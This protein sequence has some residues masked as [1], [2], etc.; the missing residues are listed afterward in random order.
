MRPGM[1]W[2][3]TTNG[4]SL[5]GSGSSMWLVWVFLR[6]AVESPLPWTFLSA[7][8]MVPSSGLNWY[9]GAFGE[10]QVMELIM[11]TCTKLQNKKNVSKALHGK[12][13]FRRSTSPRNGTL[14]S[15]IWRLKTWWPK[16]VAYPRWLCD[17]IHPESNCGSLKKWPTLH[18]WDPSELHPSLFLLFTLVF[19]IPSHRTTTKLASSKKN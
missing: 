18:F 4:C 5:Y 15:L 7:F 3:Q 19:I 13:K 1:Q 2:L 6:G 12:F 14:P 10:P 17:H 9:K 16:K 8:R 11:P